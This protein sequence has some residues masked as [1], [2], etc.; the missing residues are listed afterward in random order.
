[1]QRIIHRLFQDTRALIA[2]ALLLIVAVAALAAPLYPRSPTAQN[3]L[4][5]LRPPLYRTADILYPLG[6][7]QLGRDLLARLLY[8]AR[9]SLGIGV[10]AVTIAALVGTVLGLVGGYFGGIVDLAITGVTETILTL[11]FIIIAM[12]IIAALGS[13]PVIVVLTLG[14]TGWVSF[15]KLIRS[16]VF[17]LR[18]E[19][20]VQAALALGSSQFRVLRKHILPNVLP[21][22]IVDATLQLGTLILAEAGLS[23][24]GLGIQPPTPTW[25]GI[26]S[27]GQVFVAVAWWI[28]TFP[29]I[30]LLITVLSINFLGDFLRDVLTKDA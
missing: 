8:G 1:M 7:D 16:K 28:P 12:A 15:A 19:D 26:L 3:L 18:S 30:L 9:V 24:L 23:F 4:A 20:Y 17:E 13:S 29:G 11:P 21:L 10:S 5:T 6:S 22:I 2:T 25:G 27:E 14:L